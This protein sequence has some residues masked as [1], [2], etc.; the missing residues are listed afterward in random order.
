MEYLFYISALS[1]GSAGMVPTRGIT[2]FRPMRC[3]ISKTLT[4]FLSV[5]HLLSSRRLF[6]CYV[7]KYV[8]VITVTDENAGSDIPCTWV[9]S[10][11]SS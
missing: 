6:L 11:H 4:R 7:L 9:H 2:W 3:C 8:S 10:M 5:H 1:L